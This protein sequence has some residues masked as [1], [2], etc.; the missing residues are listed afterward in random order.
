LTMLPLDDLLHE[1]TENNCPLLDLLHVSANRPYMSSVICEKLCPI[2]SA[3]WYD[4][5]ECEHDMYCLIFAMG[6]ESIKCQLN[7]YKEK[8]KRIERERKKAIERRKKTSRRVEEVLLSCPN[9]GCNDTVDMVRGLL[10]T[11]RT[12]EHGGVLCRASGKYYQM[13]R[14]LIYHTCSLSGEKVII[15]AGNTLSL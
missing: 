12:E 11:V 9:C 7:H 4:M 14:G 10:D 8:E 2:S 6:Y 13:G 5:S 3:C 1:N 15:R